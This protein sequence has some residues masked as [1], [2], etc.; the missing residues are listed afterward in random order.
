MYI[1]LS[2]FVD[3]LLMCCYNLTALFKSDKFYSLLL[4]SFKE[5]NVKLNDTLKKTCIIIDDQRCKAD[6][7]EVAVF[8]EETGI[9]VQCYTDVKDTRN[10]FKAGV[11]AHIYVLRVYSVSDLAVQF[12]H[13]LHEADIPVIV[14]TPDSESFM[15][16]Q[17]FMKIMKLASQTIREFEANSQELALRIRRVLTSVA[18]FGYVQGELKQVIPGLMYDKSCGYLRPRGSEPVSLTGHENAIFDLLM[19][20][21]GRIV[22]YLTL[23]QGSWGKDEEVNKHNMNKL[24]VMVC[25]LNDAISNALSLPLDEDH[26]VQNDRNVG[27]A[28]L[29]QSDEIE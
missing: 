20:N 27:Y 4:F 8:L 1:V 15:N 7:N 18:T 23:I 10:A 22:D 17:D 12:L 24:R 6:H 2:H 21:K 25:R 13:E 11:V 16:P 14:I 28:L 9:S 19:E 5:T 3:K 26:F 29:P